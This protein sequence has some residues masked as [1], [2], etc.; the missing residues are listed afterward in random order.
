MQQQIKS[1][2]DRIQDECGALQDR[3]KWFERSEAR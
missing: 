3:V 2:N 1:L